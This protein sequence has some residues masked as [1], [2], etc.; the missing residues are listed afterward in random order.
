MRTGVSLWAFALVLFAL[1]PVAARA[2]SDDDWR[3]YPS[4]G[5][6]AE[7]LDRILPEIRRN[8]PGRFYDAEGPF[9]GGD[10]QMHYRVKWMT[11]EGRIV[12]LDTDART[13]RVVGSGGG[14]HDYGLDNSYGRGNDNSYGR[15]Q[16]YD[17]HRGNRDERR[18]HFND[19]NFDRDDR[20]DRTGR[21]WNGGDRP[22]RGGTHW[23]GGGWGGPWDHGDRH[24]HPHD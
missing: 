6:G 9:M 1:A 22:D 24:G 17:D 13:G 18:N 11:P 4:A 16:G 10:G 5:N 7:P 8:H 3:S 2:Q 20:S 15:D 12:W 23:N 21:D 14:R 19:D